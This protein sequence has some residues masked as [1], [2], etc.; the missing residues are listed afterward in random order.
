[1]FI[2]QLSEKYV[3]GVKEFIRFVGFRNSNDLT[4]YPY[5]R[6]YCVNR[7][8]AKKIKNHLFILPFTKG[9]HHRY[10]MVKMNSLVCLVIN[11]ITN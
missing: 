8:K 6:C 9:I 10:G 2:N 5:M 7:I 4:R 3:N 11:K 1:M